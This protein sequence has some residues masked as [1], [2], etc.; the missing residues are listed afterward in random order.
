[1][2][3][4]GPTGPRSGPGREL[5]PSL[6]VIA[7]L[8]LAGLLVGRRLWFFSDDWNIFAGYHDGNLLEPFN[9]HL[10]LLPA[11]TYQLLFRTVGVDSYLPFRLAGMAA[12][13]VLG[14]QVA[15]HS[16]REGGWLVGL[17]V[18]AAVMWNGAGETN[19]LF[20][21]LMNFSLPLAALV[22]CWWHLGRMH[23]A[24][25]DTG[26]SGHS[27][28]G[29]L[30]HL[31]ALGVWVAVALASSGL[32]VVVAGAVAL[33]LVLRREPVRVWLS[34]AVPVGA[35]ALWWLGHR[36]ATTLSFDPTVVVPYAARMLLAGASSVA[37]GSRLLGAVL[38]VGLAAALAVGLARSREHAPRVVAV[39]AATGA[40]C[41]LT[42]MTRQDTVVPVPPDEL[43][44]AWTVGALLVLSALA[45]GVSISATARA[46][47][48][49]GAAA[50]AVAMVLVVVVLALDARSLLLGM[51]DWSDAVADA[52][53]GLRTNIY[54]VEALGSGRVPAGAVIGPLSYVP[55]AAGEFL[56]GVGDVGSPLAGAGP[57]EFGGRPEQRREA[58]R[59]FFENL[60]EPVVEPLQ[61]ATVL[62]SDRAG[63][64]RRL[65]LAP[66]SRVAVLSGSA[67]G[68]SNVDLGLSR[69]D[70][71]VARS[72]TLRGLPVALVLPRDA[73]VGTETVIPY[74]AVVPAGAVLC[75]LD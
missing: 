22:A 30:R 67:A 13:G 54:A 47:P 41:L 26:S 43:R 66:G 27:T 58:E 46:S 52:A 74:T 71:T 18:T 72:S 4:L 73:P 15:R 37:A 62:G 12:L 51:R 49:V 8:V 56:D 11:G 23:E 31:V 19:V 16:T 40:F 28:G 10:S 70:R 1:M 64:S 42:A 69:F 21:F 20:P 68:P 25:P 45:V 44:Y 57:A 14:F 6:A 17:V 35:W 34:W 24:G 53:P 5:L 75:P 63:C 61:P 29:D 48:P 33:E 9:G 55:V 60:P 50:R 59:F 38:L 3:P 7:V 65:E 2:E 39:V 32:G 36:G